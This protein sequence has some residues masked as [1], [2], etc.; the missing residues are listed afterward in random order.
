MKTTDKVLDEL[1][2]VSQKIKLDF[3]KEWFKLVWITKEQEILTEYLGGCPES[4]YEKYG[5]K[6]SERVKNLDKFYNSKGYSECK[7]RYGGQVISKKSFS[8]FRNFISLTDN[9][10]IK[11]ILLDFCHRV[12]KNIGKADRIAVLT[13]TNIKTEKDNLVNSILRH[14]WVHVLLDENDMHSN[15]WKYNEGLVTYFEF[16]MNKKLEMLDEYA[17]KEKM[18]FEKE[19]FMNGILFRNLLKNVEDKYKINKIKEF[20]KNN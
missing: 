17:K 6:I 9:E 20:L 3:N 14:E 12:E 13:E 18:D 4:V 2:K 8:E 5:H 16:Y 7:I 1:K 19:Y 15:N 11:K 10:K